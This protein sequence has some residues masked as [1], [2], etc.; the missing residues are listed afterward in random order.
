MISLIY[1]TLFLMLKKIYIYNIAVV[2]IF[3]YAFILFIILLFYQCK[4]NYH[5]CLYFILTVNLFKHK[6][7]VQVVKQK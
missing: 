7:V 6:I 1:I 3:F 2:A 4:L 5:T